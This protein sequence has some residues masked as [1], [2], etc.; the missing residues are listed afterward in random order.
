MR[1]PVRV[2]TGVG[3]EVGDDLACGC[4]E[5]GVAGVCET[6]V[7]RVDEAEAVIGCD[8]GAVIGRPVVDDD[9]FVVRVVELAQAR[10]TGGQCLLAV[11]GAHDDGNAGPWEVGGEGQLG[12]GLA[13]GGERSL[14]PAIA[15]DQAEVPVVDVESAAVPLVRPREHEDPRRPA[16]EGAAD[17]PVERAGLRFLAVTSAVEAGLGDDQG[18]VAADVLEPREIGLELRTGLQEDVEADDVDERKLEV[19]RARVVD[20]GDERPGVACLGVVVEVLQESLDPPP[21]VPA[22]DRGRDLVADRVAE[23]GGMAGAGPDPLANPLADRLDP[24]VVV[25][26]GDVL[27]PR[28]TD[29]HPQPMLK[30][31][32]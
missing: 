19:L 31:E 9:H 14:G 18:P 11:V 8:L 3:V 22:D 30:R 12:E 6:A 5:P 26:E 2:G 13:D 24:L 21:S 4:L 10:E 23:H 25:Q 29:H 7:L 32:V 15:V 1:E 20:V 28:Q 27:L 16:G 17:L